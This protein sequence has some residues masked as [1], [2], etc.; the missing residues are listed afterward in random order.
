LLQDQWVETLVRAIKKLTTSP[1]VEWPWVTAF[2][3]RLNG[4]IEEMHAL[5]QVLADSTKKYKEGTMGW[6]ARE[7]R[8]AIDAIRATLTDDEKIFV[9]YCRQV[10]AHVFQ[11]AFRLQGKMGDARL[12]DTHRIKALNQ[13]FDREELWR[14]VGV[15]TKRYEDGHKAARAFAEKVAR[16]SIALLK[17][18]RAL[19]ESEKHWTPQV[20]ERFEKLTEAAF[21]AALLRAQKEREGG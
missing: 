2:W 3:I 15:V 14:R 19:K 1:S 11:D 9:N 8:E 20:S 5:S 6:H 16:P 18:R 13:E 7:I 12:K 17:A 4:V 21:E 10:E